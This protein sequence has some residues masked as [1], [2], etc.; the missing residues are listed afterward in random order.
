VSP[1]H[2]LVREA[3]NA[4]LA[5]DA[6]L[7]GTAVADVHVGAGRLLLALWETADGLL[8]A[9]PDS[10]RTRPSVE[11]FLHSIPGW[12]QAVVLAAAV[13]DRDLL[14]E[15]RVGQQIRSM[16]HASFNR[17]E[18]GTIVGLEDVDDRLCWAV[19]WPD[20]ANDLWVCHDLDAMHQFREVWQDP[21]YRVPPAVRPVAVEPIV[22]PEVEA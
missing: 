14:P 12:R 13:L 2:L 17:F 7:T 21:D 6:S 5:T 16:H 15:H 8:D 11:S 1:S 3:A 10:M 20:G 18:W 4:L 22:I 9:T 19:R